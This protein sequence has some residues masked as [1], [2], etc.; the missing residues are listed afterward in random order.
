MKGKFNFILAVLLLSQITWAQTTTQK[1]YLKGDYKKEAA[2]QVYT[3]HHQHIVEN[4]PA[5]EDEDA[6]IN[7]IILL[8]GDGMGVS[9]VFAGITANNNQLYLEYANRIGLAKTRSK[10]KYKT[11]SAS[12]GTSIA[13]G[14]KTNNGSVGVDV[15]NNPVKSIVEIASEEGKAT[16]LVA[17]AKITHATPA[18]FIAHVP[19]RKQYEDIAEFFITDQLDVFIGGGLD[20]FDK[21]EDSKS[22]LP[23]LESKNFQVV[24][25]EADLNKIETGK[26]AALLSSGHLD[27]YPDRGEFLPNSTNKAIELLSQNPE[28]FFLMVEGSQIDWG[29][30]DNDVGYVVEEMLDFDRTV[31]EALKFAAQDG[32]TLVIITADHETGGMSVHDAK[33]E[34]GTVEGRFTTGG[35]SSMMVPVFAYGPGADAFMGIYENTELFHKMLDAFQFNGKPAP[36]EN[37]TFPAEQEKALKKKTQVQGIN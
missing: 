5:V 35:H 28:G 14:V 1:T 3:T 26:V 17:A 22:L 11:D 30:H 21:R 36:D 23:E 7:N 31:G 4:I 13:C 37:M 12:S 6:E 33:P 32:H 20:D 34:E 2:G 24:K 18:S 8:I 10:D 15:N 27:R 29:G 9:Q 25:T 19:S 16:G